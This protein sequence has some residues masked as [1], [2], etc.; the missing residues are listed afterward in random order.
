MWELLGESASITFLERPLR[1]ITLV[2]AVQAALRSRRRQYQ[3]RELMEAQAAQLE[4]IK[5]LNENLEKTVAGL[6][7]PRWPKRRNNWRHFPIR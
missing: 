6:Q 2:S 4:V 3:V 7:E 1:A 5:N